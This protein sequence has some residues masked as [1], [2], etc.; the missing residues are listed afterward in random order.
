MGGDALVPIQLVVADHGSFRDLVVHLP[1]ATI[2]RHERLI[3]AIR[4]D[5]EATASLFVDRR[6]LVA[7]WIL[8]ENGA[9]G[10]AQ[11]VSP[12]TETGTGTE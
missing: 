4:E 6:R 1:A 11:E 9:A 3:D 12:E 5:P 2:A 8:S 7:A 10:G